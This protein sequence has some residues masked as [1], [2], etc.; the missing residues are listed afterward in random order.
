[1]LKLYDTGKSG[2]DYPNLPRLRFGIDACVSWMV[3]PRLSTKCRF[4]NPAAERPSFCGFLLAARL[5]GSISSPTGLW[6]LTSL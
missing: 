1:M 4:A 3:G 5:S 6:N 2:A